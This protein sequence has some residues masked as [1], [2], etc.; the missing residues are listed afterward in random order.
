MVTD[1]TPQNTWIN[2]PS[3]HPP[4]DLLCLA[5]RT[6]AGLGG[7]TTDRSKHELNRARQIALRR[8]GQEAWNAGISKFLYSNYRITGADD[9]SRTLNSLSHNISESSQGLLE[10]FS[11]KVIN[12][13]MLIRSRSEVNEPAGS[14]NRA[15]GA[16]LVV[17]GGYCLAGMSMEMEAAISGVIEDELRNFLPTLSYD[18][19][20]LND[21]KTVL[22][23]ITQRESRSQP[24]YEVIQEQGPAHEK[25]FEIR[26]TTK[27]IGIGIGTGRSKKAAEQA[28]AKAV[29]QPLIEKNPRLL[30]QSDHRKSVIRQGTN[31][32]RPSS[33]PVER[34]QIPKEAQI[35]YLC[36]DNK[37]LR[38]ALTHVSFSAEYGNPHYDGLATLGAAVFSLY[39]SRKTTQ[40]LWNLNTLSE[41]DSMR[42]HFYRTEGVARLFDSW[43][44]HKW[45]LLGGGQRKQGSTTKMKEEFVQALAG[46]CY[47]HA[48]NLELAMNR[49]DELVKLHIKDTLG[50]LQYQ[51]TAV[52]ANFYLGD[53]KT[54]LQAVAQI[55]G[56]SPEYRV[57]QQI[58]HSNNRQFRS[59]VRV[60]LP[61][62]T[63]ISPWLI[64]S[65]ASTI[66]KA[67]QE[68]A[69]A[70]LGLIRSWLQG[71]AEAALKIFRDRSA[72]AVKIVEQI[73]DIAIQS[74]LH[75]NQK[76]L[77]LLW[78]TG[79]CIIP[80][81]CTE[82]DGLVDRMN[83]VDKFIREH[84]KKLNGEY[85]FLMEYV[86]FPQQTVAEVENILELL[87]AYC[88][89]V[90]PE[91]WGSSSVEREKLL[92]RLIC[93][94]NLLK[95]LLYGEE[96][97][98][99]TKKCQ[100]LA[101]LPHF[102]FIEAETSDSFV[103]STMPGFLD[104]LLLEIC[105]AIDYKSVVFQLFQSERAL[106][107]RAQDRND[108]DNS[109][110]PFFD[111]LRNCNDAMLFGAGIKGFQLTEDGVRLVFLSSETGP[112]LTPF[113][114]EGRKQLSQLVEFGFTLHDV[115][116]VFSA[117]EVLWKQ[118][119]KNESRR[120]RC[121]ADI[122][123]KLQSLRGI[124][125]VQKL[126]SQTYGEPKLQ[127]VAL[128]EFIDRYRQRAIHLLPPSTDF[129]TSGEHDTVERWLAIDQDLMFYALDNILKNANEA[130]QEASG[131]IKLEWII[132]DASQ[133][134]LLSISDN[135]PG[136]SDEI[137]KKVLVGDYS[138]KGKAG[139]SG[140][141]LRSA[142]R[143]VEKHRGQLMIY[144]ELGKGTRVDIELPLA[145]P[146]QQEPEIL[147][148]TPLSA[149]EERHP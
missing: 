23:A 30:R 123:E 111:L 78:R 99:L 141:G 90:K 116:N 25:T 1:R 68:A 56:D 112:L 28:A 77:D 2:F 60:T 138:S 91:T 147:F 7:L 80:S 35:S 93:I 130:I 22:Q 57:S 67:D 33:I 121:F 145:Q 17:L 129:S 104:W 5:E 40:A 47:L 86:A 66:S 134:V 110:N 74:N 148:E 96:R 76:R 38:Q 54:L 125:A 49:L 14:T 114:R 119:S 59:G 64:G 88:T 6:P 26:V 95:R 107:I 89:D 137:L 4:E 97:I 82:L 72:A 73:S 113:L 39:L 131:Q 142:Q 143:I 149:E 87:F 133:V 65:L 139:G 71:G 34:F 120:Y 46:A 132:D 12:E 127:A 21:Y 31:V 58:G 81:N 140:L 45:V 19:Y 50:Q 105:E 11:V 98:N 79:L 124:T 41:S 128:D 136:M 27:T 122:E 48:N 101:E 94:P 135:G 16:S 18:V 106:E 44:L 63:A 9:L 10:S 20:K 29:L 62:S 42:S 102:A 117:I 15:V 37:L 146:E 85:N 115:K 13:P 52:E 36:S 100:E 108:D 3:P 69:K 144:S 61:G 70:Y 53:P 126:I 8:L 118:A 103:V 109:S 92:Q 55:I 51:S 43:S 83:R 84:H 32:A 75:A 24:V